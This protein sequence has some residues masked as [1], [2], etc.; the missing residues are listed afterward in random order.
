MSALKYQLVFADS[1]SQTTNI[2]LAGQSDDAPVLPDH[3]VTVSV[4]KADL[5]SL[6]TWTGAYSSANVADGQEGPTFPVVTFNPATLFAN[7]SVAALAEEFNSVSV[8]ALGALN[9]AAP[10]LQGQFKGISEGFTK[11]FAW[12]PADIPLEAVV[13]VVNNPMT[14]NKFTETIVASDPTQVRGSAPVDLYEQAVAADKTK[15]GGLDLVAGDA[16]SLYITYTLAKK[17]VYH[18]DAAD[19]VTQPAFDGAPVAKATIGGVLVT[20]GD[21][22]NATITRTY[23]FEFVVSA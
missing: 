18:L 23:E 15:A 6:L 11:N 12:M 20:E 7:A 21:E 9:G 19:S 22:E 8:D 2:T 4:P 5:D 16:I 1:I 3:K 14:G 13:K 10:T 17:R